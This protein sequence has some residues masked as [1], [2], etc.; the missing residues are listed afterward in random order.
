M[1]LKMQPYTLP[2]KVGFNYE[3]LKTGLQ[4]KVS[5]YQ[6]LVYTDENIQEAKKDK[7]KLNKLKKALN[8]ERIRLQKE[9]LEPFN[10]FKGQIDEL[11][12]I[13]D[14]PVSLI[15]KQ[16]KEYDEIQKKKKRDEIEAYFNEIVFP[17]WVKF[18]MV[19]DRTWLNTSVSMKSI[20]GSLDVLLERIEKDLVTLEK[21]PEFSFESIEVY[22]TTLDI[23]KAIQEGNRLS[24]MQKKKQEQERLKAEAKEI[25]ENGVRKIAEKHGVN[26]GDLIKVKPT[27][28]EKMW[29]GFKAHLTVEQAHQ[30]KNFFDCRGIEF[31]QIEI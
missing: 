9:Y 28:P 25:A 4:E 7:A 10:V 3:E 30:L 17:D 26:V 1:E 23:N 11:I 5:M 29:I 24:E 12:S 27:E 20:K 22:K 6:T 14:K 8:D 2:E 15:D 13:I 21:L 19:F 31:E 18:E 16:V